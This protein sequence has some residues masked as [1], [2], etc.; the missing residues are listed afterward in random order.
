MRLVL[1]LLQGFTAAALMWCA[2]VGCGGESSPVLKT[3]HGDVAVFPSDSPWNQR[4]DQL[5]VHPLSKA[6]IDSIGENVGM[7]PDFG[8]VYEGTPIGIPFDVVASDQAKVAVEFDYADESDRGPYPLFDGVRIEGEP[9]ADGDRHV[10]LIDPQE[11]KLYELFY[12]KRDGDSWKAGSGAIWD[13]TRNQRRPLGWTSADAAGLPIFPG[14]VRFDEVGEAGEINHA[15]LFTSEKTRRAFIPPAS[16]WA[17][18]SEDEHLPP[19]GLRF[20]LRAD[21]DV[22]DL[23]PQAR[24]VAVALQRYGMILADNG[25]NWFISGAHDNRWNDDDLHALKRIKGSDLE[26]VNTGKTVTSLK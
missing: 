3:E 17:S 6:Y 21:Y 22:S 15:L 14:L 24:A 26:A 11:K 5:P 9:D 16:H 12:V 20:R 19:M 2:D 10:I 1:R 18:D 23:P 13:L 4:V 25:G 8:G 7:H